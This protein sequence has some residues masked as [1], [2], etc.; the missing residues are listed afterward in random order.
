MQRLYPHHVATPLRRHLHASRTRPE[1][2]PPRRAGVVGRPDGAHPPGLR[3]IVLD[4]SGADALQAGHA[5]GRAA[6]VELVQAGD[7]FLADGDDDLAAQ[8][9]G[10]VVLL[11]EGE[12]P[13]F[14]LIRK[15]LI[16]DHD[17]TIARFDT[18]I[19]FAVWHAPVFRGFFGVDQVKHFLTS[20]GTLE[21]WDL[22]V[23][24]L[25]HIVTLNI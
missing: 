3:L 1:R 11:A 21:C 7:L 17:Y 25:C 23:I 14:R 10:Q 2:T 9:V 15:L 22:G 24:G 19:G 12:D 16:L 5:V 4:L 20:S 13:P 8:V 18:A 6:A